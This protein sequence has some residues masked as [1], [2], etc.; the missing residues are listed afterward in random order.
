MNQA[1]KTLPDS[2]SLGPQAGSLPSDGLSTK[3]E[4]ETVF[5]R[6]RIQESVE[7]LADPGIAARRRVRGTKDCEVGNLRFD[8]SRVVNKVDAML[9]S[10]C[11]H[12]S[13][14]VHLE[15]P[16][17]VHLHLHVGGRE[18]EDHGLVRRAS[19]DGLEQPE[20]IADQ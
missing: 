9:T 15:R 16:H 7:L 19:A 6:Q 5:R 18:L 3:R 8:G 4:R 10:F 17:V 12:S 13:L 1:G 20:L 11:Y 14:T 2:M